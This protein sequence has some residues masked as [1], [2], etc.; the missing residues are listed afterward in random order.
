ML[1]AAARGIWI[2]VLSALHRSD[3]YT[4][5]GTPD[6]LARVLRCEESELQPALNLFQAT[7]LAD[8]ERRDTNGLKLINLTCLDFKAEHNE[9]NRN[10]KKQKDYR[11]R[12]KGNAVT[13]INS[14]VTAFNS[15]NSN[16]LEE[17]LPKRNSKV[18]HSSYS[19]SHSNT[20]NN[21]GGGGYARE[22]SPPP[23]SADFS[24]RQW[25]ELTEEE[26]QM[27]FPDFLT[28]LQTLHPKKNIREI[29]RKVA[30]YCDK[31][32][33]NFALER[34]KG[35]VE[36]EHNTVSEKEFLAAL[37]AKEQT[38]PRKAIDACNL[39]DS[40]G[41]IQVG[42]GVKKCKHESKQEAKA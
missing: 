15:N 10:A 14:I 30:D 25:S 38:N 3:S 2:D 29:A 19:Y 23:A 21:G 28:H 26:S 11:E 39:C 41:W 22:E 4:L 31:H 5:T 33:K 6:Q 32:G 36:G 40:A 17:S 37:G 24:K 8:F 34:V 9:R 16:E 42:D 1:T 7:R 18:S 27:K 35:W 12:K 20:N 13:D